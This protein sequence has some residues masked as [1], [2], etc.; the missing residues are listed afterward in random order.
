[1]YLYNRKNGNL[2][3]GT[4][5]NTKLTIGA[6]GDVGIGTTVPEQRLHVAEGTLPSANFHSNSIAGFE[7]GSGNGYLSI[8]TGSLTERGLLFG[9]ENATDRGGHNL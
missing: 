9:D 6:S 8:L 1:M 7:K 5:N 4:N 3:F 2:L